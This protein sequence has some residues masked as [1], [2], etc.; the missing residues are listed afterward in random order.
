MPGAPASTHT[1]TASSTLGTAPP[2]ELRSV[3]T[4]FT[5][6]LN[7]ATVVDLPDLSQ[8]LLHHV[9]DLLRPAANLVLLLA[10]EHHAQQRLGAR[11]ADE[12]PPL[13]RDAALH[14]RDRIGDRGDA[15]QLHFFADP[16]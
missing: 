15:R 1:R 2:R 6:T 12:Q 16:H 11:V 10:F 4:L 14:A 3:A 7:R 8:M 5:L 13:A 9:D